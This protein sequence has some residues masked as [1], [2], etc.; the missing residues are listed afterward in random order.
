MD[1]NMFQDGSSRDHSNSTWL[2][3]VYINSSEPSLPK[4]QIININIITKKEVISVGMVIRCTLFTTTIVTIML[5][6]GLQVIFLIIIMG[7]KKT[8]RAYLINGISLDLC[9]LFMMPFLVNRMLPSHMV[10]VIP[11][12]TH[13][14][15]Q[16]V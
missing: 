13:Y 4:Y 1:R 16:H 11:R 12:G 10:T 6:K 2:I 5:N 7:G 8:A 14:M 15:R 3:M 9:L